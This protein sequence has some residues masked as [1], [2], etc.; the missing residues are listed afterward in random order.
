MPTP[1]TV[2]DNS[3]DRWIAEGQTPWG[4][5]R[6]TVT[7]AN[8]RRHLGPGPLHILDAG[9]GNG[10]DSLPLAAEGHHITIVDYSTEMLVDAARNAESAQLQGRVALQQAELHELPS[11]FPEPCFDLVL[12][13]NVLQY[14]DDVPALMAALAAPLRPG[15]L[16]SIVSVNRYANPTARPSSRATLAAAYDK[17]DQRDETTVLFGATITQYSVEEIIAMLPDTGCVALQDYGSCA[18]CATIGATNARKSDPATFTQLER[19]EL[20]LADRHYKL[21][22]RYFHIVARKEG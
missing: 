17:L 1:A 4:Q 2:F 21:L 3:I 15:G 20:A 8:L 7:L 11:L 14:V 13:H 10:R 9:G 12:C 6:V 5:L 18:A 16:L 22:A 19:L